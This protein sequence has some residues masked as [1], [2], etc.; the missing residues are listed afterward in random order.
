MRYPDWKELENSSL[1]AAERAEM[2]R[3]LAE[4]ER[5]RQDY[6]AYQEYKM[7]LRQAVLAEPTPTQRLD[8]M[9]QK[10]APVRRPARWLAAFSAGLALLA[11]AYFAPRMFGD[12]NASKIGEAVAAIDQIASMQ[13]SDPDQAAAWMNRSV[14][15]RVPVYRLSKVAKLVGASYGPN[16]AAYQ[17]ESCGKSFKLIVRDRAYDFK[18]AHEE[19]VG[20]RVFYVGETVGWKCPSCSYEI[21]GGDGQTRMML[22]QEAVKE[23]F[24]SL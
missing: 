16:W 18:G 15:F 21:V 19:K 10:A 3:L 1:S 11:V 23:L 24:G 9:L 8:D 22:A 7:T 5:A 2:E 17:F 6:A 4:D 12:S 14:D 20:R 13:T